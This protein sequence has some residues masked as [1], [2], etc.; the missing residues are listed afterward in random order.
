MQKGGHSEGPSF[1]FIPNGYAGM[2]G[3]ACWGGGTR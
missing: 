3:I 2:S 1:N